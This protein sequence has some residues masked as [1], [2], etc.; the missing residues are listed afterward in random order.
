MHLLQSTL[1]AILFLSIYSGFNYWT[2]QVTKIFNDRQNKLENCFSIEDLK[3][4]TSQSDVNGAWSTALK[5][6]KHD[7]GCL[8]PAIDSSENHQKRPSK[9]LLSILQGD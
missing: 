1:P 8:M 6:S 9:R 5:K 2:Y 4:M 3:K 7:L